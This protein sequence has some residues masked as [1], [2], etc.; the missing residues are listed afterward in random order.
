MDIPS[1]LVQLRQA[2]DHY[3]VSLA[4]AAD[5]EGIAATTVW[6]WNTR[7]TEPKYTTT[8]AILKRMKRMA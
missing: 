4:S 5:A 2:A 7:N 6:R 3:G 1:Y 8:Q